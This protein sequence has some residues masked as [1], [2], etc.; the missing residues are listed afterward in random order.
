MDGDDFH[1]TH[2]IEKMHA[3]HPL[4]DQDRLPWLQAIASEIDRRRA[5]GESVIIACSALKRAY[6]DILVGGHD[7]VRI[8]YLKGSHD[9]IA[10]RM[11]TRKGHFMP[12]ELLDS[13]FSTLEEP[14]SDERP[15]VV[16]IDAPVDAIVD[17]IV[18]GLD[19]GTGVH[20]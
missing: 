8:V 12:P 20:P 15:I 19:A 17:S 9:V 2:D 18:A 3:G 16:D 5:L 7:D 6:R 11:A 4:D 14:G 1:S 10:S 13:Q